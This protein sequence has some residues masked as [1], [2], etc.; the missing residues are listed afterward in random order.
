MKW[1]FVIA[2]IISVPI[3]LFPAAYVWHTNAGGFF[4]AR[5][6]AKARRLAHQGEPK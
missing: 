6:E 3:I 2:L 5:R 1:E 4:H